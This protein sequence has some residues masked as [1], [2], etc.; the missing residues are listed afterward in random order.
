MIYTLLEQTSTLHKVHQFYSCTKLSVTNTTPF[1][2]SI[3]AASL[4]DPGVSPDSLIKIYCGISHV[5][6][7]A[8]VQLQ[9]ALC[10]WRYLARVVLLLLLFVLI[11]KANFAEVLRGQGSF[12]FLKADGGCC[13]SDC[14]L[15]ISNTIIGS[16]YSKHRNACVTQ[17]TYTVGVNVD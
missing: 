8:C 14:Y 13:C 16:G 12:V 1:A 6:M 9:T 10:R 7:F 3:L 5:R 11:K 2:S 17:R 15:S 4:A